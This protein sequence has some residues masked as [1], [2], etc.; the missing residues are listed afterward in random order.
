MRVW[1]VV[2][3]G[4]W[5]SV[6]GQLMGMGRRGPG[7]RTLVCRAISHPYSKET[8]YLPTRIVFPIS[9][10]ATHILRFALAS[11]LLREIRKIRY[12]AHYLGIHFRSDKTGFGECHKPFTLPTY[13]DH[14]PLHLAPAIVITLNNFLYNACVLPKLALRS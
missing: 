3:C 12:S 7:V 1:I 2:E 9:S 4:D 11:A 6:L 8:F 10:Q 13:T 5:R 14:A